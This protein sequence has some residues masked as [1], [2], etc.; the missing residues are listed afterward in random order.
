MNEPE[1]NNMQT[2]DAS[3]TRKAS[4]RSLRLTDYIIQ[5][6]RDEGASHVFLVPGGY[7]DN[8]SQALVDVPGIVPIVCA[9]ESGAAFMADGFARAAQRF[10]VCM[11]ISGPGASNMLTGLSMSDI[12]NMPVLVIT[13]DAPLAWQGRDAIQ[14]PSMQGLKT[15]QLLATVCRQQMQVQQAALIE[16]YLHRLMPVLKGPRTGVAHLAVPLDVQ[17]APVSLSYRPT[18][19]GH[20][21]L[22]RTEDQQGLDLAFKLLAQSTRVVL[23]VGCGVRRSGACESLRCFAETFGIPVATTMNA[24]GDFPEDHVLSMGVFGWAGTPLANG[25]LLG[26][27]IDVLLVVGARL[28]QIET[29]CWHPKLSKARTL[30]QVDSFPEHLNRTYIAELAIVSDEHRAFEYWLQTGEDKARTRLAS[31]REQREAWLIRLRQETSPYYDQANTLSTQQA[32]HP[33]RA[34]HALQQHMPEDTTLFVDNGAHTFFATH[35]WL[36]KQA[37]CYFNVINYSGAMGWAIPASIG[38]KLARPE[39]QV[40]AV[41]GDGCMLMQGMEIQTAARYG[42]NGL[43]F[44]VINNR[45]HGNPKLRASGFTQAAAKLTDIID[46]DWA[47]FAQALGVKGLRVDQ[48]EDLDSAFE[49]A[50]SWE[51]PVLVDVKCGLYPTPT[52]DFDETFMQE[53][54]RFTDDKQ[55]DY[56]YAK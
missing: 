9:S 14:D 24:K 32:I 8:F 53:F 50:R 39:Q 3:S 4:V 30:I 34:I 2:I 29:F 25:T 21:V 27:E 23:L 36:M 46:H 7:V 54:K 19:D 11:G 5:A 44:V 47:A 52:Y 37:G 12:E 31:S 18:S 10:A 28:G 16:D 51:G 22:M 17:Q 48:V 43:V 26:N 20:S 55:A 40:V 38:A 13:G 42:L 33:A 1:K 15:T 41:V 35:Y 45:A 6:L 49:Q 56:D